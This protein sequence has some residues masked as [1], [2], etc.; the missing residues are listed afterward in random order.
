MVVGNLLSYQEGN[1]SGAMLNFRRVVGISAGKF[2]YRWVI[3]HATWFLRPKDLGFF[4]GPA[5]K[6]VQ[7]GAI[8]AEVLSFLLSILFLLASSVYVGS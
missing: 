6:V 8:F 3:W 4:L 2:R 1:F 7:F 5:G